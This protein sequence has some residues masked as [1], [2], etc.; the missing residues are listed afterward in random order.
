MW[1]ITMLCVWR[2]CV[3]LLYD[4]IMWRS[5]FD[6]VTH[7]EEPETGES[8]HAQDDAAASDEHQGNLHHEEN[9]GRNT[10]LVVNS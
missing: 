4:L 10:Q 3:A 1:D 9:L 7:L 6:C 8:Q 2:N 5:L